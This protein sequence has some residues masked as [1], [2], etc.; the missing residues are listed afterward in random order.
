MAHRNRRLGR[1]AAVLTSLMWIDWIVGKY[2]CI[3]ACVCVY[4]SLYKVCYNKFATPFVIPLVG[5][6]YVYVY[7]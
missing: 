4:I 5:D 3:Q 7:K 6:L 2:V 1:L